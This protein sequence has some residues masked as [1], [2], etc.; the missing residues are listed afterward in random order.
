GTLEPFAS[1]AVYFVVTDRFVNGDPGNDHRDQGGVNRSFDIPLP[2]CDGVAGNIGYLGVDFRG[3]AANLDYMRA[4]GFRAAWRPP[5][6]DDPAEG[7]TGG[8]AP[9]C[10]S[11]L[12]DRGKSGYRGYWGVNY[13]R[14]DEH[15]P[16][17]GMGF[18]GLARAMHGRDMKLVLDIVGNHGSPAW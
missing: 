17:P 13:H 15:L 7:F 8:A 6:V 18:P 4:M 14:V 16:S 3:L 12:S 5:L 10:D 2:P 11:V 9:G 1:H